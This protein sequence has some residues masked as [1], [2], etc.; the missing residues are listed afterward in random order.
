MTIGGTN[1]F[2]MFT[3]TLIGQG[4]P[5]QGMEPGMGLISRHQDIL[6]GAQILR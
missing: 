6:L 5:P 1:Q 3:E 2:L 4:I